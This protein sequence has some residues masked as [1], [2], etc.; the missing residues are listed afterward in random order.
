[1]KHG[2]RLGYLTSSAAVA[3][4]ISLGA[5]GTS[6]AAPAATTSSTE[7]AVDRG[8]TAA[9][10]AGDRPV[11]GSAA[12]TPAL[13]KRLQS[14]GPAG[15]EQALAGYWTP[16]RM[17]AARPATQLPSVAKA[18]RAAQRSGLRA[19]TQRPQAGS[20]GAVGPAPGKTIA[21]PSRVPGAAGAATGG[22]TATLAA[23]SAGIQKMASRA[24]LRVGSPVA[25]TS[26]KVFFTSAGY[27]YVCSGTVVNTEG[28][29]TVWT[30][31]H[32]VGMDGSWHSNW[33][34]VPNY[35]N[36]RAPYGYWTAR[37]LWSLKGWIYNSDFR[38]DVGAVIVNRN[39]RYRIAD[40]L[41]AQGI[42]WNQRQQSVCAFG[43][44][45]AY[46]FN[47][48]YLYRQCGRTYALWGAQY[49]FNNMTGGSSGGAW[50]ARFNGSW[51]R[52]NGHN[53]WKYTRWP[54]SMFSPYYGNQVANLYRAV[55]Y[56]S[57]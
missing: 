44:P 52:I 19:N 50:L 33:T 40:R 41:G 6:L 51:G 43:Y 53:D 39:R 2:D 1:M 26:G 57:A 7:A 45:A 24:N 25:R 38:Y 4:A 16:A 55:R 56:R 5:A 27:N 30:A 31:G 9:P 23:S 36:G 32:C 35:V 8:T 29:S 15:T 14:R 21:A 3:L 18:M 17:K 10:A 49:Q 42:T 28:K 46:P 54:N 11:G 34:F 13:Q 37:Q 12:L 20:P 22:G 48:R 47:G